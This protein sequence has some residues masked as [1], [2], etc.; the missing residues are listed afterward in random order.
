M[1]KNAAEPR[2][3]VVFIVEGNSDK[4]ALEKIFQ[5]IYKQK[6][7]V[8]K[9][10]GGDITS[11]EALNRLN[12]CDT[13]YQKV[14]Q[15]IKDKKLK[16]SDIWQI[17]HIFD[18]DGTY[19]PE[20][21]VQEGESAKFVYSTSKIFCKNVDKVLDRNKRKSEMMDYLLSLDKI[22]GIPY[23]GYFMSS[24]LDHA[25]YDEQNLDDELKGE[26]ADAFYSEF[27]GKELLFIDYLK[28]EVANGVPD[29]FPASWRYIKEDVHSLERHTNLHIYF[30][31]NPYE[32]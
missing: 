22:N 10:M 24:N 26:Y 2:K 31:T 15:Y 21:A 13:I 20:D 29:S 19:V 8:F 27:Q 1:A 17:V 11:D 32:Y 16:K 30:E 5:K 25:L 28:D 3:A 12:V 7:I 14:D 18:T 23:I 4:K 9:F 6:N